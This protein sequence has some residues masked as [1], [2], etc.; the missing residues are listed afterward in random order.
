MAIGF[1]RSLMTSLIQ[2]LLIGAA[3]LSAS[4]V[5]KAYNPKGPFK[6]QPLVTG[7]ERSYSP[8]CS[9]SSKRIPC[10][11]DSVIKRY[12]RDHQTLQVALADKELYD[13]R[14][15]DLALQPFNRDLSF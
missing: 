12:M 2:F 5:I 14:M 9:E 13:S 11:R 3:T 10:K 6:F 15:K 4:I 8:T 7:S 1:F